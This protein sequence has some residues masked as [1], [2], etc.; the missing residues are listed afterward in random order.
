MIADE[1]PDHGFLS[2]KSVGGTPVTIHVYVDRRRRGV[3]Q[4]HRPAARPR[5]ARMEN[6]FY[7]DR[8]GQF[9]D[10]WGHR[11]NVASHVEDV[12]DEEMARRM[13]EMTP[14]WQPRTPGQS[15]SALAVTSERSTSGVS[16]RRTPER[17]DRALDGTPRLQHLLLV[18]EGVGVAVFGRG[19]QPVVGEVAQVGL[20]RLQPF[21]EVFGVTHRG[22][23]VRDEGTSEELGGMADRQPGRPEVHRAPGVGGNDDERAGRVTLRGPQRARPCGRGSRPR[24][25]GSRTAYAPPAPQHR[26]SSA[27]SRRR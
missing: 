26:P 15:G 4:G 19:A 27:V 11:W 12:S 8:S 5:P 24:A 18:G 14:D 9:E 7:G 10:P 1:F 2:P 21:D 16:R 22:A 17:D 3:R 23:P 25:R 6:Q 13:A 20:D